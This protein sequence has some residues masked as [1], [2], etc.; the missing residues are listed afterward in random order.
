MYTIRL[1]ASITSTGYCNAIESKKAGLG[2]NIQLPLH[3]QG[4]SSN[5]P[6]SIINYQKIVSAFPLAGHP[7]ISLVPLLLCDVADHSKNSEAIEKASP[8][9]RLAECAQSIC[10]RKLSGDGRR[11]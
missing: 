8:V 7:L 3:N 1:L 11:D 4:A 9:V 10:F 6:I 5:D 2:A